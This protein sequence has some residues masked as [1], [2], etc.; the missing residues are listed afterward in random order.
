MNEHFLQYIWQ[1]KLYENSQ[2]VT[3]DNQPITVHYQGDLNEHSGPDFFNA[4]LTIGSTLWA[5]NVEVHTDSNHWFLHGHH[6]DKAYNN[7]ILHVVLRQNKEATVAEN[8]SG[9]PTVCIIPPKNIAESYSDFL[10]SREHFP[11]VPHLSS[12]DTFTI[13]FWFE[14][15][16]ALR[17]E[18]RHKYICSVLEQT[19]NDWKTAFYY[20]LAQAFGTHI[21]K[22]VF[23]LLAQSVPLSV[24]GK[25]KNNLFQLE[26]LFFGTANLLGETADEYDRRL[27][28]EFRFLCKKYALSPIPREMWKFSRLRPH[29]SPYIRIAQF[30]GLLHHQ[31]QLYA[32][33]LEQNDPEVLLSL[34]SC[35]P[36]QFW[37]GHYSFSSTSRC[38]SKALSKQFCYHLLIN[39]VVP[40]KFSYGLYTQDSPLQEA[41]FSLLSG[42]PP[43]KNRI[44]TQ[45]KDAGM[46]AES[47]S[48]TQA[49]IELSN[50]YCKHEKCLQCSIG[51]K[52]VRDKITQRDASAK[53][54]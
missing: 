10:A 49:I 28:A 9:I 36:S 44:I 17:F 21:N 24:V 1:Q 11:C 54:R 20:L 16:V 40:L 32:S 39:V 33:C 7:V 8:G 6:K 26:A 45:W 4:K 41:A 19:K 18:D 27:S 38:S 52:I 5:G 48:D 15:L 37:S 2:L 50:V 25:L 47:A 43:E 30:V 13:R 34:F 23:L 29:N 3:A 53:Y 14:K 35:R 46:H 31:T 22:P 12:I 42:I 51:N